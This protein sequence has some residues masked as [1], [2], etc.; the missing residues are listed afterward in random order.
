MMFRQFA[1][2]LCAA[3]ALGSAVVMAEEPAKVTYVDQ[4]QPIFRMRCG[5]CHNANDKKGGLA[6]DSFATLMAGG[7]SG[8]VLE[9]G[10]P[11][12]SYLW[13]LVNHES[14][15]KMPPNADKL[16]EAELAVIKAWIEGG[17]LE[18]SGSTAKIKKSMAV[19]KIEV[20]TE[21]PA[22]VAMP[23]AY[24]GDSQ[25]VTPH[26]NAVTA[27]AT[28]PWAP[29][30]AVSSFK[31]IAV[32]NT[33]TL[34]LLGVLPFPE[35]QAEILKFSRSGALLLA[36]GGRGGASGKVVL[37]DVRSGA[38]VA[39]IGDEYDVVLAADVSPDHTQVALGGPKKMLR[40]YSVET[41]ELMYENKKHTD[42]VTAIEFSPDGVLLAS[43]D[44][45]NGL[46]VWEAFTGRPFQDLL[47]HTGFVTDVSWRSD[48]NVLASSS[49]DGTIRL[50]EMNN[51]TQIKSWNAHGGVAAM[52]YTR[53]GRFVSTG[54]DRIVRLW[55]GDGAQERE[56]AG[57][58]D[59]GMEVAFDAETGRVLGGDWSG[60][61]RLWNAA[62]GALVG[63]FDT[64]PPTIA[65]QLERLQPQLSAAETQSQQAAAQLAALAAQR[66][67][68]QAAAQN[69]AAAAAAAVT[70][71]EQ[72]TAARVET[73]K[74]LADK[75]AAKVTADQALATSQ[76]AL[77]SV[78]QVLDDT[79]AALKAAEEALRVAQVAYAAA[80]KEQEAA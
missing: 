21:R 7:S 68:L 53:D 74:L 57:M 77:T 73:D 71:V 45:A 34:E 13:Q 35:G 39:E 12:A 36:G 47:G 75:S 4:V 18:N 20:T 2:V 31:Q 11:D 54:R 19:A 76:T 56:F 14:E 66:A 1:K 60:I 26:L 16:P 3:C 15:P 64:N 63:Q 28:S 52:D 40:V 29:L 27:L 49:E 43:G 23:L 48:S 41:G 6:V 78:Q 9:G 69:A 67:E 79:N 30:A 38:R 22:D 55:N 42:W 80:A 50:W 62:D 8:T 25:L 70:K 17:L 72:T 58:T 37:F 65:L 59:L 51:G 61:V 32:Y 33:A 44:R 10:A 46:V 5:S 24:L